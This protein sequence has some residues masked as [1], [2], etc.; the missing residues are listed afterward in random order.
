VEG[1]EYVSKHEFVV[2]TASGNYNSMLSIES[3]MFDY[4]YK[5][6]KNFNI[7]TCPDI[8]KVSLKVWDL[9][10]ETAA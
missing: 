9:R 6:S 7:A 4:V 10:R 2:S 8:T 5:I 3:T 1:A